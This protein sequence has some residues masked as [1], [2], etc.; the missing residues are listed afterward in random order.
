MSDER[1]NEVPALDLLICSAIIYVL[2]YC[3][4]EHILDSSPYILQYLLFHIYWT[5]LHIFYLLFNIYSI[6]SSTHI[7]ATVVQY[8]FYARSTYSIYYT[9]YSTTY[10]L[11]TVVHIPV[12]TYII[13]H[14]FYTVL[15][16]MHILQS[17]FCIFAIFC[18]TY[19]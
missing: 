18:S 1:R 12:Y 9:L 3:S 16:I 19:I 17:P 15:Y 8:I 7:Q 5:I 2:F 11:S 6:Y 10:M 4:T 13:R 14:I